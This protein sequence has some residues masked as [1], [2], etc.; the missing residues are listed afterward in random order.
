MNALTSTAVMARRAEPAD[1]LD[2]FPTPPWATRAFAHHVLPIV[3]ERPAETLTAADPAC[4]EGHM[5]LALAESFGFV[6]AS[7]IF[8]YG[9]GHVA[10]F[11]HPDRDFLAENFAPDWIVTNPPFNL[12]LAFIRQGRR[13]ARRGTA[14]LVR[15]QFL[16]GEERYEELFC[17]DPPQLVMV[18]AERVPMHRGR[19][20]I[21]GT[22]ATAYCWLVWRDSSAP[23][24]SSSSLVA[25]GD[26]ER[27]WH[28]PLFGWI[29]KSRQRLAKPDDWIRFMGC[30]DLPKEHAAMKVLRGEKLPEQG[31]LL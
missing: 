25:G 21:N 26:P 17:G 18:Y 22:T 30:M 9:F 4:G 5:A 24:L 28:R 16:E 19:W 27:R 31:A 3:E 1:S 14:M 10:D 11:L 13:L 23:P 20:V 2:Y 7:D 15:L 6:L 8:G 12:A 29:P